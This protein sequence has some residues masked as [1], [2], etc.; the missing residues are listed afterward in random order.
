MVQDIGDTRIEYD[1]GV[2]QTLYPA[3]VRLGSA[4]RLQRG[5]WLSGSI[6]EA[7][8]LGAEYRVHPALSLRG[9]LQRDLDESIG[10]GYAFGAGLRYAFAQVDYAYTQSPGLGGTHRFSLGLAFDLTASAIKIQEPELEPVFPALQ[11]RYM[12]QPFGRV[13]LTNTSRKPLQAN[14]SVFI[15]EAMDRPT[16]VKE[17]VVA[18]GS[19]TVDLFALFGTQLSGWQRNRM[20][21][22]EIQVSYTEGAR[23]RSAKRQ[24]RVTIYKRN[25][26]QW[27]DIGA[28]AAFIS[29]DDEAVAG[30]ASGMLRPYDEEIK[31]SGRASRSLL[32]ALVLFNALSEHG[33]RYLA[34]PNTPYEQIAGQDFIVDSIQYPAELLYRRSGDCDD[35]T[36]LYCSLLA[37]ASPRPSSTRRGIS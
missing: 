27:E 30:F 9:G 26:I 34:D 22:A 35:C 21:P 31:Q 18:P 7:A 28:A 25:A 6:D 13:K 16:E 11:K 5:L 19:E 17:V 36:V 32:R 8:H 24:G 23:T 29:P 4:Y 12:A 15:P 37:P 3:K 14:L 1:N 2:R 20:V 33:V 10:M